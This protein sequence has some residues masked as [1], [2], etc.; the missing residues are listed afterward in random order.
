VLPLAGIAL[1][2]V[3]VGLIVW[4]WSRSGTRRTAGA[5]GDP[6]LNGRKTLDPELEKR[7]DE[8]LARFDS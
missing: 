7:L 5:S 8:E 4:R 6:A 2:A 1:G 3:L